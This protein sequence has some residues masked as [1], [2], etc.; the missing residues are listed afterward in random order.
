M[1]SALRYS[2][3]RRFN[4]PAGDEQDGNRAMIAQDLR[5]PASLDPSLELLVP[6]ATR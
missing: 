2:Q 4:V 5:C 1:V 3:V 6:G